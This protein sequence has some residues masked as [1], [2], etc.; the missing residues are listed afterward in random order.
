M[1]AKDILVKPI[2]SA[3][4]NELV[5]RVHYSGKVVQNSQLHLGVYYAGQLEGVMSF[6]PSLDKSKLIGLVKDT[7]WNGFLELN[8]MAFSEALPRNS[9]SRA[10]SIAMKMLKKHA[11]A[12]EWVVSFADATQC[13][14]GTIYR[15][16]GFVLTGLNKNKTILKMPDGTITTDISLNVSLPNGGGA[17]YWKRNGAK[18]LDG[19]QM[20]YIYFI[21]P[22][23]KQRLTVPEIP[24]SEIAVRGATMYKG[25]RGGNIEGDVTDFQ[26]EQGGSI[27]T[28]LLQ[29]KA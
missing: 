3:E 12:V 1:S 10:I 22:E 19:F 7:K 2:K 4:A 26:S 27:P 15:A 21:N 16:S 6:G 23:A 17:G 8:R 28:P 25:S 14:D 11:P 18:P 24:F 29:T 5:K 13:G 20:R 9:E